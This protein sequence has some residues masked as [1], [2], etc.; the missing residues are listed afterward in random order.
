M[1]H[2]VRVNLPPIL[3]PQLAHEQCPACLQLRVAWT[4]AQAEVVL[5]GISGIT[6]KQI[7][8]L[9]GMAES[10]VHVHYSR[11]FEWI[12]SNGREGASA[13]AIAVLWQCAYEETRSK[14][15]PDGLDLTG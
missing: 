14:Y 4:Y 7:G 13:I 12:G 15:P 10:T 2:R 11:A 8:D 1:P 9:L 6:Y 3:P 5:A